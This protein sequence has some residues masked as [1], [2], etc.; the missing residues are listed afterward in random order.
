MM[1]VL[2]SNPLWRRKGCEHTLGS[3]LGSDPISAWVAL[4]YS[5]PLLDPQFPHL[6]NGDDVPF[7]LGCGRDGMRSIMLS[8]PGI[9]GVMTIV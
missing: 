9:T 7:F 8:V 2:S 6:K 5:F 4:G 3:G 1:T